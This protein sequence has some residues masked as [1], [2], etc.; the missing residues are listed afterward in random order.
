M[1]PDHYALDQAPGIE[2]GSRLCRNEWHSR[3]NTRTK[4]VQA[5]PRRVRAPERNR[6]PNLPLTRRTL[7]QLS[8]KGI[9]RE[10]CHPALPR[11]RTGTRFLT[12]RIAPLSGHLVSITHTAHFLPQ[13]HT[14][15]QE[16]SIDV[17][18][19]VCEAPPGLLIDRQC[20][21]YFGAAPGDRTLD[22]PVKSRMLYQLS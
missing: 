21:P 11:G 20:S 18:T 2:P 15:K 12:G 22:P 4:P 3:T 7:C 14:R 8:Y 1:S 17:L 16:A 13:Q 6:T 19:Q 10:M 5:S 9:G